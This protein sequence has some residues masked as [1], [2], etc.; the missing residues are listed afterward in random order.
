MKKHILNLAL[1]AIVTLGATSCKEKTANSEEAKEVAE[2]TAAATTF[3]INKET[4]V[5]N[6]KGFKPAESHTGTLH[7]QSGSISTI[8][9]DIQAGNFVVDMNTLTNT[10][11]EGESKESLEGHLKG[12]VE[13]KQDHFFNVTKYPTAQFELTGVEGTGGNVTV[14][15]NLTIKEVTQ[16]ISFPAVVSFPGDGMFLKSKTFTIDRTKWGVNFMS[17]SVFDD[18]KDK[19]INDE[20]ELTIELHATK[21]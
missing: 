7:L 6:W 11:L 3:N 17:K 20:I 9:R 19:F 16:N 18:L 12:T 21:A 1:I 13:E 15:G 14:S 4:S 2:T 10:D 8:E 5:I